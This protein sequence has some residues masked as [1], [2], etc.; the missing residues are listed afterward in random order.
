MSSLTNKQ[1]RAMRK[2]LGISG[3]TGIAI[4]RS[5]V[6]GNKSLRTERR[7]AK[8]SARVSGWD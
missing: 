7:K 1:R 6:H 3:H 2:E 8:Q 4:P 5:Q